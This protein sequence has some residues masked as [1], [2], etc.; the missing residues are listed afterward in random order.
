[1]N[2]TSISCTR[3]AAEEFCQWRMEAV[4]EHLK[5]TVSET[6]MYFHIGDASNDDNQEEAEQ[7]VDDDGEQQLAQWQ[8]WQHLQRYLHSETGDAVR[9][10]VAAT[11]R[12]TR[13]ECTAEAL[14]VLPSADADS[15]VVNQVYVPGRKCPTEPCLAEVLPETCVPPLNACKI[16]AI[17]SESEEEAVSFDEED[18]KF[19]AGDE[20]V[21]PPTRLYKHPTA[22]KTL[23]GF[24]VRGIGDV[25]PCA[26]NPMMLEG[27]ATV[28][29]VGNS[30]LKVRGKARVEPGGQLYYAKGWA[31]KP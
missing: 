16:I 30:R 18:Q 17:R 9:T 21:W 19:K 20:C 15:V 12:S 13:S 31:N 11:R 8:Q 1:M 4:G 7:Q 29:E 28:I 25:H 10:P 6:A 27:Q 3:L 24:D 23:R 2:Q 14:H 22:N 26:D 5:P